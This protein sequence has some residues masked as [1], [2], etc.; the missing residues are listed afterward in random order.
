MIVQTAATPAFR[1]AAGVDALPGLSAA[2]IR[3]TDRAARTRLTDRHL[4]RV[5]GADRQPPVCHHSRS[6]APHSPPLR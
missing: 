2:A 6:P 4:Q 3:S 1:P 5:Q